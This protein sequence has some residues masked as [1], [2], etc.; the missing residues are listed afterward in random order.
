[1]F[2]LTAK[3]RFSKTLTYFFV[4]LA[5]NAVLVVK[6]LLLNEIKDLRFAHCIQISS[7]LLIKQLHHEIKN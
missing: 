2:L 7:D 6:Q 1:M 4:F 3:M 5:E